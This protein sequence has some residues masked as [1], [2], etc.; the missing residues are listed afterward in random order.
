MR[1]TSLV[2]YS[3]YLLLAAAAAP[4]DEPR[5]VFEPASAAI[6]RLPNRLAD[7]GFEWVGTSRSQW[8]PYGE[9]GFELDAL[10]R[11]SGTRSIRCRAFDAGSTL[12]ATARIVMKQT[13]PR[14]VLLEVWS[15]SEKVE[16]GPTADYSL[17]ADLT[18]ADGS[19]VWAQHARCP[20]GTHDWERVELILRQTQPIAVIDLYCLFRN[21]AGT[22]WFDDAACRALDPAQA[23][24][25]DGAFVTRRAA[26]QPQQGNRTND[27]ANGLILLAQPHD[28]NGSVYQLRLRRAPVSPVLD[29]LPDLGAME[30]LTLDQPQLGLNV[31]L[32]LRGHDHDAV[33]L[34]AVRN[35]LD[36]WRPLT[37]FVGRVLDPPPTRWWDDGVRF[38]PIESNAGYSNLVWAGAGKS[39]DVSRYPIAAVSSARDTQSVDVHDS[40]RFGPVPAR[41]GYDAGLKLL[42]AA[43]DL[44][45][46]PK[47]DT[48]P[49]APIK[50]RFPHPHDGLAI[51]RFLHQR[52]AS[53]AGFRGAWEAL[54]PVDRRPRRTIRLGLWMP[55]AAISRV[56]SPEDFGFAYKEGTDDLEYDNA[57]GILTF[58]YAEPQSFWLKMAPDAPRD[59]AACVAALE[60][61]A[62]D[63]KHPQHRE[64][65][66]AMASAC[67]TVNGRYYVWPRK[68][69]WCDGAV[70]ALSPSPSLTGTLT[71]A[72]LNFDPAEAKR[73]FARG[74]DGEY[75]DSLDGWAEVPDFD[76]GHLSTFAGACTFDPATKR[77]CM[78]NAASIWEYCRWLRGEMDR[79]G[80]LMMANYCPTRYWWM[81]PLFD[82]MGQEVNWKIDGQW[83][84]MPDG[85]LWYRRA[86]C[87]KRPYGLLMNTDFDAWTRDDSR[88]YMM[89]CAAY[90]FFPG[91]FS[92]NAATKQYFETP[93]LYNRDRPLF[94]QFIPVICEIARP[95]WEPV[96]DARAEPPSLLVERFQRGDEGPAYWTIHN[97]G[98]ASVSG[99]LLIRSKRCPS[100]GALRELLSGRTVRGVE[101]GSELRIDVTL[102]PGETLVW[103]AEEASQTRPADRP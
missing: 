9:P 89:K 30:T 44:M 21:T 76:P 23:R 19:R 1:I 74:V 4:G 97:P 5:I 61:A 25:F 15:R 56:E 40:F 65:T 70:F 17:Y 77:P 101:S 87:G 50:D 31:V 27:P 11:R 103:R 73:Y 22:A 83:S 41:V 57:H 60:T 26:L 80:K 63:A 8:R 36:H 90:G 91:F 32:G 64:A 59:Y 47:Q 37:I 72:R 12:G 66:A 42:Y 58:H 18:L 13:Q 29:S 35:Q 20:T 33:V 3:V 28:G 39:G 2:G 88:R 75:L 14:A 71:K 95:G 81:A 16:A 7:G 43:F 55:F 68:E 49:A 62:R 24:E 99:R 96:S 82:V 52:G 10:V 45:L 85:E 102:E 84:P 100:A 98:G 6:E 86:L 38:R 78:L 53:S 51:V 54:A 67:K 79:S 94:K 92:H 46:R 34:A 93:E 69:P 48:G